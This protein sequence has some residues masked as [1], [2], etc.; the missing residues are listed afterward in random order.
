MKRVVM[1]VSCLYGVV[2]LG[3]DIGAQSTVTDHARSAGRVV[4]AHVVDVQSRFAKNQFGDQLILSDVVLDVTETLKG[5]ITKVMKVTIEGGT[6][7]DLT[8]KVSDLPTFKPG[9]RGLFFLD[10]A[11]GVLV[12]HDRGRGLLKVSATGLIE[13]S[14]RSL[15]EVRQ[16]VNQAVGSGR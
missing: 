16:Q 7:G 2:M 14:A 4:V 9:D 13:G 3:A 6:I 12:P 15:D 10:S 1:L 8:L 5:P 11:N